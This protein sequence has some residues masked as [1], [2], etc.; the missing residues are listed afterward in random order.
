MSFGVYG[1]WSTA[2]V[3]IRSFGCFAHFG[4]RHKAR[5][6]FR[7]ERGKREGAMKVALC[8]FVRLLALHGPKVY[9]CTL[10]NSKGIRLGPSG[11]R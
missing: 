2:S 7:P 4:A 9:G 3:T 11:E 5:L 1:E 10:P 8:H 6:P